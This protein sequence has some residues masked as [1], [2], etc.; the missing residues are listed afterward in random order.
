MLSS[1]L[2]V[3]LRN[4]LRHKVH[5]LI[6]LVGLSTGLACCSL[7]ALS[8]LQELGY[9]HA[10]KDSDRI[11][12]IIRETRD[13]QG[14]ATFGERTSGSLGK[15][16]AEEYPEVESV[17][18]LL[19]TEAWVK[20]EDKS[21]HLIFA[22]CDSNLT[23]YF[24]LSDAIGS[25]KATLLDPRSVVLTVSAARLLFGDGDPLG[26]TIFVDH[27]TTGGPYVVGAVIDDL[28]SRT[29]LQFDILAKGKQTSGWR[30][31]TWSRTGWRSFETFVKLRPG[32]S[33]EGLESKI[34]P[35]FSRFMGE[36]VAA[37]NTYHLQPFRRIYLHSFADY[38]INRASFGGGGMAYGDI[39]K[40]W[41]LGRPRGSRGEG[42]ERQILRPAIRP[43]PLR[44]GMRLGRPGLVQ[45]KDG[46]ALLEAFREG[47]GGLIEA[48]VH[49]YRGGPGALQDVRLL[50]RLEIHVEGNE[51]PARQQDAEISHRPFRPVGREEAHGIAGPAARGDER[52]GQ[53]R[54]PPEEPGARQG[55]PPG[56]FDLTLQGG[57]LGKFLRGPAEEIDQ[58]F[59]P[60]LIR[61]RNAGKRIR[62]PHGIFERPSSSGPGAGGTSKVPMNSVEE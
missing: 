5:T 41:S 15:V 59:H 60:F 43:R 33:A 21:I 50:A 57:A 19:P 53:R 25:S 9:D 55:Y 40:L 48:V 1:Y 14:T 28:P 24:G 2:K 36:K 51:H 20:T 7:I 52:L 3:A 29:T 31:G 8:V 45:A 37:D 27:S 39:N 42:N 47:V 10:T 26:Q 61:T 54:R 13:M 23:E 30:W 38:G 58:I 62:R 32:A 35:I 34:Q 17:T 18:R 22:H 12:K 46:E 16:I 6:N 44:E 49:H 56:A 4:L 11:Y